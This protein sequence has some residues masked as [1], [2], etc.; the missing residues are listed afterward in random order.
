MLADILRGHFA[1]YG[2]TGNCFVIGAFRQRIQRLWR[3]W[4]ARRSQKA[5]MNWL[6]FNRLLEHYPLPA[7]R[8]VHR[9]TPCL[10]PGIFHPAKGV[11]MQG[12]SHAQT[13]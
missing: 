9:L 3:S 6:R 2:I 12:S 8:I 13:L 1:H 4:L 10:T 5:R 11:L 7:V